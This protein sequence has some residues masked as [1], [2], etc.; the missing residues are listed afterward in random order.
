[1]RF[2]EGA[3][4]SDPFILD[5]VIFLTPPLFYTARNALDHP[6]AKTP[7]TVRHAQDAHDSYCPYCRSRHGHCR[8]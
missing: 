3:S 8:N 2:C 7:I 4:D 5:P 6:K 1:M